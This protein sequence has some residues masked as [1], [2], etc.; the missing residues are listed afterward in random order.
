MEHINNGD[1]ARPIVAYI[2]GDAAQ[3]QGDIDQNNGGA[4][5]PISNELLPTNGDIVSPNDEVFD[6]ADAV[7]V[8][9]DIIWKLTYSLQHNP[10]GGVLSTI[11]KE[12]LAVVQDELKKLC[13]SLIGITVEDY[14][15]YD[16][17]RK[18]LILQDVVNNVQERG[19]GHVLEQF[20]QA[21][22][23]DMS[24]YLPKTRASEIQENL[25]EVRQLQGAS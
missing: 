7:Y 4:D 15:N 18:A 2:D 11:E 10:R 20:N 14:V 6:R 1:G 9:G 5:Q 8:F 3:D 25:D 16:I 24:S 12:K 17:Y 19:C 22:G 13:R 23:Q 21:K